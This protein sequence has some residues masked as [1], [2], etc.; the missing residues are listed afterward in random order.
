MDPSSTI[1][2]EER[3]RIGEVAQL[4]DRRH[5]SRNSISN[6]RQW[7]KLHIQS[8]GLFGDAPELLLAVLGFI[9]FNSSVHVLVPK[10]Q[11]P[12]KKAGEHVRHGSD[13][14]SLT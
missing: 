8:G 6:S 9:E 14:D 13:V 12:A 2:H 5:L 10:L 11:H 4:L 1:T 3:R 7:N